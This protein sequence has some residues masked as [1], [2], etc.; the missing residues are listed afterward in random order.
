MSAPPQPRWDSGFTIIEVLIA[1]FL[2][3]VVLTSAWSLFIAYQQIWRETSVRVEANRTASMALHRIVYGM[4]S[5]SCGLRGAGDAVLTSSTTNGWILN[6]TDRSNNPA[7]TFQYR[8]DT[9]T[10]SYTPPSGADQVVAQSISSSLVN[11]QSNAL[12]VSI[13]V[14]LTQGRFSSTRQLNTTVRWRN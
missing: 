9:R 3:I 8:G 7:G 13:E 11:I 1:S 2:T 5:A 4:G 12:T 14:D 6:Y 10:L